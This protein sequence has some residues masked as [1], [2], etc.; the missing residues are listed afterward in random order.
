MSLVIKIKNRQVASLSELNRLALKR[1]FDKPN[2]TYLDEA[3]LDESISAWTKNIELS[4]YQ[5]NELKV[6]VNALLD[7]E[8][9]KFDYMKKIF[10][11]HGIDY[12]KA[13]NTGL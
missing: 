9:G 6:I 8:N 11:E 1:I 2:M 5:K 4:E 10:K 3:L 13:Y 7:N 12:R